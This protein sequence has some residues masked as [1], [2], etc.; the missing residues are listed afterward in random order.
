MLSIVTTL[1]EY[2]NYLKNNLFK[3]SLFKK[4]LQKLACPISGKTIT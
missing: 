2:I 3:V 1:T 4:I